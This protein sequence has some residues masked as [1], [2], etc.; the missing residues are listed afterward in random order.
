MSCLFGAWCFVGDC[1]F[2]ALGMLVRVPLVAPG[3][4]WF[5][6]DGDVLDGGQH[7][8]G[9][10]VQHCGSQHN[11]VTMYMWFADMQRPFSERL[12]T[13]LPLQHTIEV[14][15]CNSSVSLQLQL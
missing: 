4:V 1:W 7:M 14:P 5:P 8:S 2:E 13:A 10:L 6:V 3:A 11:C 9:V 15:P 12:P